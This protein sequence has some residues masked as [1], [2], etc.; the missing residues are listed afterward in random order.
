MASPFAYKSASVQALLLALALLAG[1]GCEDSVSPNLGIDRPFT[2]WGIFNARTDTHA[3]RVF[4]IDEQL[5]LIT[6]EPID[7]SVRSTDLETGEVRVW[8]DSL[9]QLGD[10]DFRH[11][12]WDTFPVP[13]GRTYRLE[14]VRSDGATSSAETTIPPSV[15]LEVT[16]PD[17]KLLLE[18]KQIIKVVGPAPALPRVDLSYRTMATSS[19]GGRYELTTLIGYE[20]SIER[21]S[22]GWNVVVDYRRDFARILARYDAAG[23]PTTVLALRFLELRVHVG[24]EQWVSPIGTFDPE[25]LVEPGVFSNVENGFGFV[26][27]GYL[28]SISW[29]PPAALLQRAGFDG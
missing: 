5:R 29:T 25:V 17:P 21:T 6:A 18:T 15:E 19:D 7:A 13:E 12:Y 16:E 28:I 11:V 22:T 14:A 2:L 4:V 1:P 10:G 24:D 26:G 27:S 23:W 9:V 3:V 8:R 20:D